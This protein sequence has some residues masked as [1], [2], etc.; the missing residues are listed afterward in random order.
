MTQQLHTHPNSCSMD[1]GNLDKYV[2]AN[3]PGQPAIISN[4]EHSVNDCIVKT[5]LSGKSKVRS[6][7]PKTSLKSIRKNLPTSD[8]L[9]QC[10]PLNTD[11]CG[12]STQTEGHSTQFLHELEI[13]K[14]SRKRNQ[15]QS[16]NNTFPTQ[17]LE[18]EATISRDDQNDGTL[19]LELQQQSIPKIH[20][21][22]TLDGKFAVLDSPGETEETPRRNSTDGKWDD[23]EDLR[24]VCNSEEALLEVNVSDA[25]RLVLHSTQSV[26]TNVLPELTLFSE[27]RLFEHTAIPNGPLNLSGKD[28]I[29]TENNVPRTSSLWS[30]QDMYSCE[31][32]FY[33]MVV[34]MPANPNTLA[35]A[36][37]TINDSPSQCLVSTGLFNR[38]LPPPVD[39]S[40]SRKICKF[41]TPIMLPGLCTG[42]VWVTRLISLAWVV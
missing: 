21:L 4:G 12:N 19:D 38:T 3:I 41:K 8:E 31:S 14:R 23:G 40:S 16:P 9:K 35:P 6:N 1:S 25:D 32:N 36:G 26:G 15:K 27:N 10:I 18:E 39:R 13:T 5:S 2:P 24:N 42:P 33:S 20:L 29:G 37:S 11:S 28:A 17:T 30:P 7:R 22:K 34:P